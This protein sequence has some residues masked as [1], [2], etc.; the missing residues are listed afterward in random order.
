[1]YQISGSMRTCDHGWQKLAK[2]RVGAIYQLVRVAVDT[3]HTLGPP[4][5]YK[6]RDCSIQ[7]L[8][9]RTFHLHRPPRLR[10]GCVWGD[11]YLLVMTSAGS[12]DGDGGWIGLS[13]SGAPCIHT[14]PL[15]LSGS[16]VNQTTSRCALVP[17]AWMD[18]SSLYDVHDVYS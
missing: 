2:C 6:S 13:V 10:G 17:P 9:Q 1:M 18:R 4:A 14:N 8:Q 12:A 5:Y 3:G 15:L 7:S 11:Q 16:S